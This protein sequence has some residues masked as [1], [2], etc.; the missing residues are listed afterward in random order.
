MTQPTGIA[1]AYSQLRPAGSTGSAARICGRGARDPSAHRVWY[2][3]GYLPHCDVPGLLQ[4]ITFRL[5]DSLPEDA[6]IRLQ[7]EDN[8]VVR[9]KKIDAWLDA[10][11]GA[12]WLAQPDIADIVEDVLLHGDGKRYRLI[13]WC[14]MP[15]HVHVLIETISG[16]SLPKVVQSWK[17]F[18]AKR[19]NAKVGRSGK[20]WMAD[21]F[22]RY[23]RDDHHFA[24]LIAYI[25]NNP[26]NAGLVKEASKWQ[27][28]SA[29][30]AGVSP[31]CGR[32][33]RDPRQQSAKIDSSF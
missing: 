27:H 11:H 2:S 12:C 33:A 22:D 6:L 25:H 29:G 28:S 24:A 3:R 4:A 21:Y 14:V 32:D 7:Q 10:G 26:V 13:A 8:D 30:I 5:A 1:G 17:S 16:Y 15:N 31:A 9:R 23:I 18:S 20:V 19:V